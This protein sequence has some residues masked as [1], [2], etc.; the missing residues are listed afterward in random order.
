[1]KAPLP[2]AP[3]PQPSGSAG[4]AGSRLS[5]TGVEASDDGFVD[6]AAVSRLIA[7]M[8]PRNPALGR[9]VPQRNELVLA[10]EDFDFAGWQA[11]ALSAVVPAVAAVG[12]SEI[13]LAEVP[14]EAVHRPLQF[15]RPAPPQVSPQAPALAPEVASGLHRAWLAL[16][17]TVFAGLSAAL[18][19]LSLG[20]PA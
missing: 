19:W 5:S 16:A 10:A 3:F 14:S 15:R 11:P 2:L 18:I 13:A 20:A 17:A 6:E 1:M 12:G 8:P 7:A 9:H 4:L